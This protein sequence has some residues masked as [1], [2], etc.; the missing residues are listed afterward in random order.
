MRDEQGRTGAPV[1]T[2]AR[3]S[4]GGLQ[5]NPTGQRTKSGAP[6]PVPVPV[7][8]ADPA[9]DARAPIAATQTDCLLPR[10]LTSF[11]GLSPCD[12]VF[13]H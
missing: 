4:T 11:Q 13:L 2:D 12:G 1:V 5:P 7:P 3:T 10:S 9:T 6:V 8:T